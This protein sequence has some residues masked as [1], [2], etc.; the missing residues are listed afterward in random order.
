[1]SYIVKNDPSYDIMTFDPDHDMAALDGGIAAAHVHQQNA[2]ISAFV[3]RGG[4]LLLW[5]GFNDPGPSALSSIAYF[6]A[7][8][9]QV[10][11]AT[12]S[13]RLFLAPGVLHCSGGRGPDRFDALTAIEMWVEQATP[14]AS[15]LATNADGT[16]SRPLCPYPQFA[17]YRGSGDPNDASNFICSQRAQP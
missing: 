15:L 17:R 2:D 12:D 8:L 10:P 1:V 9:D 13:V 3:D 5:H 14:P 16:L 4:K 6:E 7:V 11:D